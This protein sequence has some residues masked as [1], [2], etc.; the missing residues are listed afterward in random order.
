[1]NEQPQLAWYCVRC[2]PKR[3]HIAAGQLRQLDG[4]EVICPR[5]KY[6]KATKRGKIWWLEAMFPGY[7]FAKFDR[8][9][10]ERAV[11]YAYGVLTIVK[12]GDFMPTINEEF[13]HALQSQL[14]EGETVVLKPSIE[15]GDEVEVAYGPLEGM[16]GEVVELLGG[17]DRVRMLIEM[18]GSRQVVDVDLFSLILQQE[19]DESGDGQ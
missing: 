9:K 8:Q 15:I 18:L 19:I 17:N 14:E 2:Q 6:R 13:I 12:F 7:L 16:Q 4:V 10:M 11:R 3:E 1:M 5:L